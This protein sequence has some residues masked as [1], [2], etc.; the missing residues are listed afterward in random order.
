MEFPHEIQIQINDYAR[1]ATRLDWKKG[2]YIHRRIGNRSTTLNG[3][4]N[5]EVLMRTV[6][7]AQRS[8][9]DTSRDDAL[10]Y[11]DDLLLQHGTEID[12]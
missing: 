5:C 10:F 6:R 9:D 2:S 1:P 12:D 7:I 11:F 4:L 3:Y 8:I